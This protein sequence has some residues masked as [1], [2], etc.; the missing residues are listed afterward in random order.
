VLALTSALAAA[1]GSAWP[2]AMPQITVSSAGIASC[3][4]LDRI[5]G[6]V[7]HFDAPEWQN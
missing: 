2:S 3:A 6:T 5:K 1:S 7:S 4:P